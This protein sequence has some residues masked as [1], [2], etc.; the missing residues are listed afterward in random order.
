MLKPGDAFDRYVIEALLGEGGMGSVYRARDT[1][2]DRRVALKLVRDD[3]G[4]DERRAE[5]RERL[6]REAR[7]AASLS[8]PSAAHVYDVGEADGV[9]F[10][11]MEL[12]RG[13]TLRVAMGETERSIA[14][15]VAWLADAGRAL[16]AAH[17]AG[18]VHRDVKPE[19]VMVS[20]DGVVKV[21]DFGIARRSSSPV[22]PSAPT[23]AASVAT[24]TLEG[25]QLG[26]PM[27]M[28]PEQIRAAPLD[29]RSDQF[30]WGVVLYEVLAGRAPWSTN[31]DALALVASILTDEPAPIE[32][33]SRE[34]FAVV[35]RALAKS[36]TD[37]FASMDDAVAALERSLVPATAPASAATPRAETGSDL[38]K[39]SDAEIEQILERA[40]AEPDEGRRISLRELRDAAREVGVE[41]A[42]LERAA[43]EIEKRRERTL[44]R[45]SGDVADPDARGRRMRGFLR[46][47]ASYV[48]V[49]TFLTFM[50]GFGLTRWMIY[51]WGMGVAMHALS[52]VFPK[53]P[54]EKRRKRRALAAAAATSAR[55]ER[56]ASLLLETAQHRF[57]VGGEKSAEPVEHEEAV[58]EARRARR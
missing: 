9:A 35:R 30:A 45:D 56:G 32:G 44:E 31:G 43:R 42:A 48:I 6:L 11:A 14:T 25:V 20:D 49:S 21:L 46:N 53:E 58:D 10:V 34:L 2:L 54:R 1:R 13:R 5:R 7:A 16:S 39:Y 17:A 12:V 40:L 51:G 57:R 52:V 24:L 4:D 47:A 29:G 15:R 3:D 41:D 8:H 26:T 28:A 55:V 50:L 38:R 33:V 27:Y 22:D 23:S 36:P 19:N 37:R 18:I